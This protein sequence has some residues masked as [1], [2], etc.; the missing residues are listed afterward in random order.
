[1]AFISFPSEPLKRVQTPRLQAE[2]IAFNFGRIGYRRPFMSIDTRSTPP[3]NVHVDLLPWL[4]LLLPF[5]SRGRCLHLDEVLL[6]LAEEVLTSSSP[7]LLV[8]PEPTVQPSYASHI[9]GRGGA[10]A[11][12]QVRRN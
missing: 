10:T 6:E 1:M 3:K 12:V 5:S 4:H 9:S 7:V 2:L 8:G 11:A